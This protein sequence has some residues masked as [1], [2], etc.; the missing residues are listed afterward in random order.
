MGF[1]IILSILIPTIYWNSTLKLKIRNTDL[2]FPLRH[3]GGIGFMAQVEPSGLTPS[4]TKVPGMEVLDPLFHCRACFVLSN[5][6]GI[7]SKH[8]CIFQ[9]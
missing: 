5:S 9:L 3:L 1:F 7:F 8:S 4:M 2:Q 6:R